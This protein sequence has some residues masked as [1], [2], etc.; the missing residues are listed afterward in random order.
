RRTSRLGAAL[1]S[2]RSV[3]VI[4]PGLVALVGLFLT[5][6][7]DHA[8]RA[9]NL[10][11]ARDRLSEEARLVAASVR[12]ALDQSDPV[13]DRLAVATRAHDPSLP[14]EEFAHVLADLM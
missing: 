14:F 7:G 6:A 4:V 1:G 8:L 11:M 9:S 12:H 5:L 13:L 10:E 3:L 2:P